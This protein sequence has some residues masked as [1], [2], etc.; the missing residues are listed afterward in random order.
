MHTITLNQ[1]II[2]D[3]FSN[4][5]VFSLVF[6]YKIYSEVLNICFCLAVAWFPP[7]GGGS[8]EFR[9]CI[10]LN[11]K[12][13]SAV[14][15]GGWRQEGERGGYNVVYNSD[16]EERR[17]EE[18]RGEERM[19]GSTCLAGP[20]SKCHLSISGSLIWGISSCAARL[21]HT[22]SGC[23]TVN[24]DCVVRLRRTV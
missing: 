1:Y 9:K 20:R 2:S 7:S 17:G 8:L 3:S 14:I 13:L 19:K 21:V 24:T 23:C 11:I 22:Q 16:T 5:S 4:I 10:W 18:R 12:D 6:K 15:W